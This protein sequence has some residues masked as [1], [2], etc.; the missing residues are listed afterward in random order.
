MRY[1]L[2]IYTPPEGGE[3]EMQEWF[4]YTEELAEAGVL[5][6]GDPLDD[7]STAVTVR[8][9]DGETLVT[10]GP[11]AE[12]REVLGGYYIVDVDDIEQAKYWAAKLPSARHG[13]SE[14]RAIPD[15][16]NPA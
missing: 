1:M 14:V 16:P 12:T 8:V 9:R 4:D 6:A 13:S 10:D 5:V 3:S 11:F 2:L 7:V 15:I